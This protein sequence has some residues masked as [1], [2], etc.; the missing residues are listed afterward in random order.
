MN[1]A[2]MLLL[3]FDGHGSITVAITVAGFDYTCSGRLHWTIN[4]G[5]LHWTIPAEDQ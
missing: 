5:F 2:L 4:T 3:L 1:P